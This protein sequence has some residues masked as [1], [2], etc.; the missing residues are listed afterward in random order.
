MAA[1]EGHF[2]VLEKLWDWAKE[3]PLKLEELRSELCLSRGEF[4]E[5]TWD[6]AARSGHVELLE[7]L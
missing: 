7:K 6:M 4:I 1:K 3:L 5:M 2:E